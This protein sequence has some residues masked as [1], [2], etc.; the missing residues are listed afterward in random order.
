MFDL[1]LRGATVVSADGMTRA[2][3]AVLDGKVAAIYAPGL[4]TEARET[5][6]LAGM[7]LLPGLVDSHVHFRDPGMVWKEDFTSG[8]KAALAGGVTTALVMPTDDPWTVSPDDLAA[9]RRLAQGRVFCDVAL[10]VA[11]AKPLRD[12]AALVAGGAVSFE[13]FTSDVPAAFRHDTMRSLDEAF[14]AIAA[15]GGRVCVSPGDQSLL[16]SEVEKLV[17]GR[18]SAADFIRSRP[19]LAEVS[20]IASAVAVSKARDVP[21]H[22]RHTSS[23][24]SVELFRKLKPGTRATI[25]TGVQGLI[26]TG[27][28]YARLGPMAKASPPWRGVGD[29][30]ALREA[31]ADGTIDI[32]VTDH[33]P[34]LLAEKEV[35][36]HDFTAVPGGFPGL[37]TFLPAMLSLVDEGLIALPDL[38]RLVSTRP[39]EIFGLGRRKGRIAEGFDADFAVLDPALPCVVPESGFH[40]KSDYSPFAGLRAS[41]SL[42]GVY[43]R[44]ERVVSKDEGM[45]TEPMGRVLGA[46]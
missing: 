19:A 5:H 18:S 21:V 38:V 14:V 42:V 4:K 12:A 22:L 11:A 30:A 24:E 36:A 23:R 7:L 9:K 40:S 25:E 1:V 15:A 28:D 31:L 10:Q 16:D 27:D 3:V 26:F 8:T 20:G 29:R 35:L 43:L 45:A 41:A 32:V 37:Q 39:A 13:L 17:P 34:H 46:G 6:D 2:D 44:G 33:A